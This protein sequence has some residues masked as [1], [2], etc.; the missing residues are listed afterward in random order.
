MSEVFSSTTKIRSRWVFPSPFNLNISTVSCIT[1]TEGIQRKKAALDPLVSRWSVSFEFSFCGGKTRFTCAIAAN[2]RAKSRNFKIKKL[3]LFTFNF[4]A[5]YFMNRGKSS[6]MN[7]SS[8]R[9]NNTFRKIIDCF[10]KNHCRESPC[11]TSLVV[12][13]KVYMR[14]FFLRALYLTGVRLRQI[15][16]KTIFQNL[17][18]SLLNHLHHYVNGIF[19][20]SISLSFASPLF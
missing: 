5:I 15:L 20:W 2:K 14:F 1:E 19:P 10:W 7:L 4:L 12:F 11:Q 18:G 8:R 17:F 13:S 9:V 3:N 16:V 6:Y